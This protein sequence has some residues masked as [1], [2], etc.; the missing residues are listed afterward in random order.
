MAKTIQSLWFYLSVSMC[1]LPFCTFAANPADPYFA[2]TEQSKQVG[3]QYFQAYIK[4]DWTALA[5][6]MA[7]ENSFD[8]KT[9]QLVF[10][11][12]LKQGKAQVLQHFT[13]NYVG[14]TMQFTTSRQLFAGNMALFEGELNW[15]LQQP[16][17]KI[18]TQKMPM[19]IVLKIEHGKV[20]EHRDYA[21]YQPFIKAMQQPAPAS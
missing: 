4:M 15:T 16:K 11:P 6:L 2:A 17:R 19:V 5:P 10:G 1:A 3:T 8:D 18:V 9:A 13:E 21:D 20:T 12:M 14:L 7:E